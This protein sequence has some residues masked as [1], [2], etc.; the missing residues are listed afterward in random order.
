MGLDAI[1][2][3]EPH[4]LDVADQRRAVVLEP[5]E[6]HPAGERQARLRRIQDLEQMPPHAHCEKAAQAVAQVARAG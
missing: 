2:V 3:A 1:A 4:A 5:F 6:P